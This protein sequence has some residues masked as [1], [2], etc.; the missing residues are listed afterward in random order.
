M[1]C[2][3]PSRRRVNANLGLRRKSQY[4]HILLSSLELAQPLRDIQASRRPGKSHEVLLSLGNWHISR[5][6]NIHHGDIR[7]SSVTRESTRC[8]APGSHR[9]VIRY[10][11]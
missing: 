6:T 1:S 8:R 11:R 7:E 10:E 9:A 2:P 5:V 3:A 4:R